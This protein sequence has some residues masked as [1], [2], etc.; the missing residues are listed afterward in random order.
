MVRRIDNNNTELKEYV[1]KY[2]VMPKIFLI[3]R[4]RRKRKSTYKCKSID[5]NGKP[6]FHNHIAIM[7]SGNN[8]QWIRK[9]LGSQ[10]GSELFMQ[11]QSI[12]VQ[13]VFGLKR[14]K[15]AL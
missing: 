2:I 12:P 4:R 14:G 11:S 10:V 3:Q 8:H 9:P 5:R 7:N 13:T 6:E 1:H 15:V